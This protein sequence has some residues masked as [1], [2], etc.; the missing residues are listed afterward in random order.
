MVTFSDAQG[1]RVG[2]HDAASDAIVDLAAGTRLPR[3]MTA[4]IA[5]GKKGLARARRAVRSGEERI[6][7]GS[8]KLHA[9][10]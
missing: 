5:L 4:F 7:A 1:M 6:P 9:L 2:V 10:R 8:V 3:D